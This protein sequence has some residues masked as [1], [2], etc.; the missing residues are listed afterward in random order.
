MPRITVVVPTYNGLRYLLPCLASL[1]AQTYRDFA[2]LVVDD[3][4]TDDTVAVLAREYPAVAVVRLDRNSG[5]VRAQNAAIAL[6]RTE[7]VALL[8]NDTEAESE[9]LA[10]LIA[11]ADAHPGA[12]AVAGKLRLWD[13][14]DILH[15]AG[16]GFGTDGVPRNLG[17]WERDMGQHD[18]GRW[19]FG[20]QGGAA[21]YRLRALRELSL[22]QYAG[23]PF[24]ST[25]FMYCEDVDLNWRAVISGYETAFAPN[26]VV[27]HHLSATAGG[28][29]ASYY[30]GRNMLAVLLKDAPGPILRRH[31]G[32]MVK[33]QMRFAWQSVRHGRERAARARLRGQLAILAMAPQMIRARRSVQRTR[34]VEIDVLENRLFRQ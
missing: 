18:A 33:A 8:N 10:C 27:Y 30:V 9:W 2:V 4:S 28:P 34:R 32:A 12:W 6:C 22:P 3:G 16:D 24:D 14:R 20:P 31:M 23:T 15:A 7:F 21:L 25:F 17:V 11:A 5:L 26:A 29:L 19:L 1:A 13:R